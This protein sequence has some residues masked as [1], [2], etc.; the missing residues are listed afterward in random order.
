MENIVTKD[1]GITN[2]KNFES[3]IS[4]PLANV[5]V[6]LG[7]SLE[8][9]NTQNTALL[10]DVEIEKPYDTTQYKFKTFKDGIIL[11]RITGNDVQPVVPRVD[12]QQNEI[13]VAY[14]QTANLY[15][16]TTETQVS[17][18]TVNVSLALANTVVANGFFFTNSSPT[19]IVGDFIRIGE[20][21]KEVVTVNTTGDFLTVN[22][23]FTSSYTNAN[24]FELFFS[25]VQYSNKFYV[26]N[27]EDQ[28][29]K[30]L[31]NNEGATSTIMPEIS[32]DGQLPENPFVETADGYKWKYMYTIPSG[33]KNKFFSDKYMPVIQ[34]NI[35]LD[36][37]V[38]G[39]I[40]IVEIISGGSGYYDGSTVNNY[41]VV[42]VTGDGREASFTVDVLNGEIVEVNILDGGQNYTEATITLDDPLQQI[43]GT[44]AVLRA[45]ISPQYGHGA[46][47]VRE[48]GAS[49]QMISVDFQD[50]VDGN[51]PVTSDGTDDFRQIC[52]V[53]DPR[54]ANGAF[55]T[56]SVYPMTTKIFT[57]D[58]PVNYSHDEYVYVGADFDNAVFTARVVHFDDN[59]NLLYVNNLAGNVDA[60]L[61]ETIYQKDA[62]S[63]FAKVFAVEE[64]DINILTGEI[65]YIK[66]RE[67][68]IRSLDQTE[69]VK[70][71]IEF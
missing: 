53:K 48:L 69:T 27:T 19:V 56:A 34:E 38:D 10:D 42:D 16:K 62:P 54:L 32:I 4:F 61:T 6:M 70:L 2:A 65:L 59:Q 43:I 31:F 25:T 37:A 29:F 57:S 64:P 44:D 68:I 40:D 21:I 13:Y 9:A 50:D 71:V 39:R 41:A 20:E 58:P 5:Y 8:W 26:R 1:F 55:A 47:S 15:V 23:N 36:N 3:M 63:V 24:V 7:R 11:K 12:W 51:Y 17:N 49:N 28:V 14:D 46:D 52:I 67:K 60:I 18:G 33:L 22:S 66:N 35:V 30:C 45:V